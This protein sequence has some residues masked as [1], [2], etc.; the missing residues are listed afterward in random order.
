MK[1]TIA[2]Q[3]CMLLLG[4]KSTY[5]PKCDSVVVYPAAYVAD[6][7]QRVGYMEVHEDSVRLGES[8]THGVV[9][10]AWE[11]VRDLAARRT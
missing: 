9:V 10:L 3:A 7:K 1:S 6:K 4:R 8:W 11:D 2:A 5:F